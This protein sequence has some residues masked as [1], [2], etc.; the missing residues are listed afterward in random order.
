MMEMI[1]CSDADLENAAPGAYIYARDVYTGPVYNWK[2]FFREQVQNAPR[3]L[4]L[5]VGD[6]TQLPK[7]AQDQPVAFGYIRR[8]GK[9]VIAMWRMD[10][11]SDDLV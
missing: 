5:R 11:G 7:A 2:T 1:G 3:T 6:G 8:D 9:S 4:I 10:D